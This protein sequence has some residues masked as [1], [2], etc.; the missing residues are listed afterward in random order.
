MLQKIHILVSS[1]MDSGS[2]K[3]YITCSDSSATDIE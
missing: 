3:S 1:L 2:L